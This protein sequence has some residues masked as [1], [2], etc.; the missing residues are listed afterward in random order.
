LRVIGEDAPS[1]SY[2]DES[3]ATKYLDRDPESVQIVRA[4]GE[5]GRSTDL[6]SFHSL[7]P[8]FRAS[9]IVAFQVL[10]L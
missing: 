1:S 9:W 2:A 7:V 5:L 6:S 10:C 8:L 4:S 3:W